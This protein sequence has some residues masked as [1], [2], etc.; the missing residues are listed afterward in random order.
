MTDD[1]HIIDTSDGDSVRETA[2]WIERELTG[3]GDV[4][5]MPILH[6]T[7]PV[8]RS[9]LIDHHGKVVEELRR[10]GFPVH[11]YTVPKPDGVALVIERHELGEMAG[12]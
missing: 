9:N 5:A 7:A 8:H 12:L 2:D 4:I 6:G 1:Q 10:R 11:G 3:R